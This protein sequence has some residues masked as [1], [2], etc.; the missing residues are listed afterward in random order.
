[1]H[2]SRARPTG[3]PRSVSLLWCFAAFVLGYG[4]GNSRMRLLGT[5][6]STEQTLQSE[7]KS[8][9]TLS[10]PLSYESSAD[11]KKS[12]LILPFEKSGPVE[13]LP[14]K[15]TDTY[16]YFHHYLKQF[17][18]AS[19]NPPV[20]F[21]TLPL[22]HIWPQYFEAYHNHWS[23]YRGKEVVFMEIGVQSGGKIPL[24][25][26]YFGPGFTYIGVDINP[27]CKM[28]ESA[29]WIHIEIG[30]SG[31]RD[32][33][34]SILDKYPKVDIFLD[35]GG[36]SMVQQRLSMEM[37]LPHIQHN[38]VF[39]CEDLST[40]WSQSFGG[41][42]Y[43]DASDKTFRDTTTVGLVH[44]TL[45]WLSA[46]WIPGGVQEYRVDD[47][48]LDELWSDTPWWKEFSRTVKHIHFY[49]Q[50]VVFEKGLVETP[51]DT[52]TVGLQI[53]Y[54]DSGEREKV[55]WPPIL[56]RVQKTTQSPWKGLF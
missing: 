34:Q 51:F 20:D 31:S 40:S 26:N 4:M 35:D 24:L 15:H 45:D 52:K 21:T 53:P 28:F 12:G 49:N 37:I 54:A 17:A 1:M 22:L 19:P 30:D 11:N 3:I 18:M 56:D 50:L 43:K 33:I 32:F 29:D 44:R 47:P 42:A 13:Y 2:I 55:D 36:H 10:S 41:I 14:G 39:M 46:G 9:V 27:T 48:Q 8:D 16:T 38:G 25:R 23:R 6:E 5:L 7:A